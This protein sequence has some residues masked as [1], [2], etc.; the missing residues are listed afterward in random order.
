MFSK[1][2]EVQYEKF[3]TLIGK[4]T[5]FVGTFHAEGTV[6][7]D[8]KIDG[9]INVKGDIFLGET[10]LITGNVNGS[11]VLLAGKVE[12][13]VHTSEQLRITATGILCGDIEVKSFIVDENA[14]FH[15]NCKMIETQ[16]KSQEKQKA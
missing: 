12:G 15:G 9:E 3:D 8:G 6:R 5:S 14:Q 11:N 1:K 4:N 2:Q 13:N 16:S 10:S 7:I